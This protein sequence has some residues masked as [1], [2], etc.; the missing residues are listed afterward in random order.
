M[1]EQP[2]D[3]TEDSFDRLTSAYAVYLASRTPAQVSADAA[4]VA[5][6]FR[7][8]VTA[9]CSLSVAAV[10]SENSVSGAATDP[11]YSA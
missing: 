8:A 1:T 9:L 3:L 10:H 6:K 5:S 2:E 11:S 4:E 7:S